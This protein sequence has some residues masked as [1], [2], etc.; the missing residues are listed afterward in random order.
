MTMDDMPIYLYFQLQATEMRSHITPPGLPGD[1]GHMH[2]TDHTTYHSF[3][4]LPLD[5]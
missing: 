1:M 5:P 2:P 4:F 3:V